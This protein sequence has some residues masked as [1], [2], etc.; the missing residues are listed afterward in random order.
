MISSLRRISLLFFGSKKI[1]DK[2]RL[3]PPLTPTTKGR[4]KICCSQRPKIYP[5]FFTPDPWDHKHKKCSFT[6]IKCP[7]FNAFNALHN[8]DEQMYLSY[9]Q[10][11]KLFKTESFLLDS[12]GRYQ[13]LENLG[14]FINIL[15][16]TMKTR[17]KPG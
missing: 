12:H 11:Y 17:K 14:F 16:F 2:N 10:V 9:L 15:E 7:V 13:L 3:P 1:Y 8:S 4:G 6:K 5:I